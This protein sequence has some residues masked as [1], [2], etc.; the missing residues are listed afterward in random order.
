MRYVQS[1][2]VTINVKTTVCIDV[3]YSVIG[4]NIHYSKELTSFNNLQLD[5]TTPTW[6]VPGT[7][8]L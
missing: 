4:L 8:A 1:K 5:I 3:H 2:L 6:I 7:I